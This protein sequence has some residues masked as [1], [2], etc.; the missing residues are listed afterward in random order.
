MLDTCLTHSGFH[1]LKANVMADKIL[2][3]QL[4]NY[5][6]NLDISNSLLVIDCRSFLAY[7]SG[8]IVKAHNA[9][10]P[11]IVRRRSGGSLSL[12]N[13]LRCEKTRDNLAQGHYRQI[14]VYDENSQDI[15]QLPDDS[16][17]TLVL[18]GLSCNSHDIDT[19]YL[20]GKW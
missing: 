14:V 8:H 15:G 9:H 4:L 17:L 6:S 19:F 20:Y 5:L 10:C 11:P 12:E 3:E 2:P 13:I 18:K 16:T 7:N 1:A